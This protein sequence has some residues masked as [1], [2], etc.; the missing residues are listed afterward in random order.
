LL[1]AWRGEIVA[2]AAHE[3]IARREKDLEFAS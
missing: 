3:L 2:G 1:A